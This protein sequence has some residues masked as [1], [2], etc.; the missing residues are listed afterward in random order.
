MISTTHTDALF[1]LRL[2]SSE[3]LAS[4]EVFNP[5]RPRLEALVVDGGSGP[6]GIAAAAV[7]FAG[8]PHDD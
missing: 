4:P 5:R 2:T 7:R 1:G 3:T 8:G 6:L